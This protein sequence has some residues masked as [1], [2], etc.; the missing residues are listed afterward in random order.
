M[1]QGTD[2][3][4][5]P[6]RHLRRT[7]LRPPKTTGEGQS[8]AARKVSGR[9][10]MKPVWGPSSSRR[11][12]TALVSELTAS[13]RPPHGTE[14][15][16]VGGVRTGFQHRVLARCWAGAAHVQPHRSQGQPQDVR[17]E[18]WRRL[19][20]SPVHRLPCGRRIMGRQA[21]DRH[22]VDACGAAETGP[23]E[24]EPGPQQLSV[25]VSRVHCV[26]DSAFWRD[27]CFCKGVRRRL[28]LASALTSRW[29]WPATRSGS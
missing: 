4:P 21:P 8:H 13:Y 29:T 14:A 25:G 16:P 27:S 15:V 6:P 7:A 5:W 11:R 12:P 24:E 23:Q 10:S 2:A 19:G 20:V 17:P 3:P 22:G 28:E 18:P 9:H 1:L 26:P